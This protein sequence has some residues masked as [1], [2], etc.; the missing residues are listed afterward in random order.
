MGPPPFH[1]HL[2]VLSLVAILAIGWWWAETRI[3]PLAAPD[4]APASAASGVRGTGGV[5]LMLHRLRLADPRP[6]RTTLF[7]FHMLEHMLIGYVVPPLLLVGIPAG[8]PTDHR[9]PP[10]PAGDRATSPPRWSAS[11]STPPSS[12]IHWPVAVAWQNSNEWAHFAI[13]CSSSSPRCCCGCRASAHPGHPAAEPAGRIGYLFL[14]T[15][16][17][18]VPAS[19]LTFS[20]VQLYPSVRRRPA[21]VGPDARRRPDDRRH[22]DEVG[23][24]VSTS[25]ASSPAS[26]SAGSAKNAPSTNSN[27][28]WPQVVS[29]TSGP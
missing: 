22:R 21:D 19:L 29:A 24:R 9:P 4:A 13:H 20:D 26:G 8:W 7:T 27:A 25:S 28:T 6:R 11:P 12:L 23:R 14:N 10:H 16:I 15:I 3:R 18:I 5:A 1:L 17:P 2:D